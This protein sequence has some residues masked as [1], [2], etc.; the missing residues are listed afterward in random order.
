MPLQ[1]EEKIQHKAAPHN[2]I[3]NI[4]K[5]IETVKKPK[6][7][8]DIE[9]MINVVKRYFGGNKMLLAKFLL[10]TIPDQVSEAEFNDMLKCI[11]LSCEKD[12]DK[13]ISKQVQ[14]AMIFMRDIHMNY[15]RT[16]ELT[17]MHAL[18]YSKE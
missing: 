7:I 10:S 18:A 14:T 5:N 15:P 16:Q 9:T 11:K 1:E 13:T 6:I 12:T 4:M 3:E 17:A 8:Q 2:F